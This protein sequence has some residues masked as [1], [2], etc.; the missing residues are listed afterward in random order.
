MKR[1]SI[2]EGLGLRGLMAASAVTLLL[3]GFPS[4]GSAESLNEAL[5]NAYIGNPTLRAERARQRAT[6][7]VVP[8]ALSGWRPTVTA[9]G[10]TGPER[11][12]NNG[13]MGTFFNRTEVPGSLQITLTQPV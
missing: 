7:E 11:V 13:V 4:T 6:D 5:V 12:N 1:R 2:G 9:Q 3:A 10:I 8:Q